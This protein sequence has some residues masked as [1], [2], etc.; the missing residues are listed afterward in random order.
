MSRAG[1]VKAVSQN[2]LEDLRWMYDTGES[3]KGAARRLGLEYRH[4]DKWA[5][6]NRIPF[7]TT[8]IARNPRDWNAYEGRRSA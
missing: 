1:W 8:M 3:G 7:W 2:R 5:R 6:R 4:L